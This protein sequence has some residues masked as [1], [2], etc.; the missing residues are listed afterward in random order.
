MKFLKAGPLVVGYENGF[1]RRIRYGESE[2]IRMIYLALRDRNWN[3]LNSRIEN[4]I[5]TVSPEAFEISYDCVHLDGGVAVMEWKGHIKGNKDGSVFFEIRGT[6]KENFKKNRAGFCVLHP[7]E[8]IGHACTLVHPDGTQTTRAFPEK[9]A[10]ENPFKNIQSMSWDRAGIPFSLQ[11]E[12]DV[13]ETEDQRNWGDASFKTFCTPLDKPFPVELKKGETVFQRVTFKPAAGLQPATAKSPTVR[14]QDGSS[15]NRLPSLGIAAS[16][17]TSAFP[18]NTIRLLSEIRFRHY[19]IEVQ[20]AVGNWVTRFSEAYEAGYALGIPLEIAL[21]LTGNFREELESFVVL[22]QQNKVRLRKVLLLQANGLVTSQDSIDEIPALKTALPGVLFGAGT[23]HN[24][25]EINKNH[26]KVDGTDF[27]SFAVDP[28]EHAFDNLTILENTGALGDLVK[29]AKAIY[30]A[31]MPVHISPLAL[32]KRF[33]PYATNPADMHIE[34]SLKGDPRQK[35]VF[36][37]VW[38]VG[39]ICNLTAGGASAVTFFQTIGHQ[40]ILSHSG[41]PYPVYEV[42]KGFAPF[43]GKPVVALKSSDPLE[44]QGMVLDGKMLALVNLTDAH[45]TAQWH[46]AEISLGPH[47]IKFQALNRA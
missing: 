37:A 36:G 20:P 16:S 39:S 9:V 25:N 45:K 10:A 35:E 23:N 44:I 38:T 33:N 5:I 19:R 6:A 26:F 30:G 13:F 40:G 28:Q 15:E 24:F 7:L 21:H 29:S 4:E 2:I 17:E 18:E 12:G 27:I 47:E 32:R 14:L 43:Q 41:E 1:L 11:F 42:L 22:C 3:T 31:E 34:E 8:T 46:N